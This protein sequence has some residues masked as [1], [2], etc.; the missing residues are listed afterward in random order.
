MG[1]VQTK[2]DKSN[3][4]KKERAA[5][6]GF[7][8]NGMKRE[9]DRLLGGYNAPINGGKDGGENESAY[10]KLVMLPG[11]RPWEPWVPMPYPHR[12][13][14]YAR[15]MYMRGENMTV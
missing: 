7:I 14:T 8:G 15:G 13:L 6:Y 4:Y 10:S 9:N 3:I 5:G 12:E 2:D 11:F 1:I